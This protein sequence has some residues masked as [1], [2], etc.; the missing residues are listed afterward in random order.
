ML[1]FFFML[2]A[3]NEF[4]DSQSNQAIYQIN[5]KPKANKQA[6][7]QRYENPHQL[8]DLWKTHRRDSH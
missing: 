3:L 6:I 1:A 7:R 8:S 4:Y 5:L 2:M